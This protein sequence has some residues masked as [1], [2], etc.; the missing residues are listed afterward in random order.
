M[1]NVE[2]NAGFWGDHY[3]W[4]GRGEE[5]SEMWGGARAQWLGS[6]YPRISLFLPAK[7]VLEIAPG[8]GR[9]TRFL[10]SACDGYQGV[11]LSQECVDACRERFSREKKAVFYKNDGK[12]LSFAETGCVDFLF[13]FDSLV[14]ATADVMAAYVPE[15]LR[16]LSRTGV[17]FIHHSNWLEVG[18]CLENVGGRGTDVSADLV[19]RM[20]LDAGGRV[21]IQEKINWGHAEC[22]DC[23]TLFGWAGPAEPKLIEN[24]DFMLEGNNIRKNQ[25]HYSR[26]AIE[27]SRT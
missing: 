22:N 5:W 20:I 24:H 7:S 16:T 13:S 9:W 19:S 18:D 10:L 26:L 17:A 21:L 11:D 25:S 6:I 3:D 12:S 8:Y 15:I 14:H 2:F 4:S 1:G 27:S 23:L